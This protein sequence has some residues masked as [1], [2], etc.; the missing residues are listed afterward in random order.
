V[1]GYIKK[2]GKPKSLKGR[3]VSIS[4]DDVSK[5]IKYLKIVSN[6]LFKGVM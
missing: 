6:N 3:K 1:E 2:T 4:F 5:L